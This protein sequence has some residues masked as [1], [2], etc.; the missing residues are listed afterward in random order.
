VSGRPI[1]AFAWVTNEPEFGDKARSL[2]N[3]QPT[4]VMT[5]RVTGKSLIFA[6]VMDP[7]LFDDVSG[8][9]ILVRMTLGKS[10]FFAP[11][12]GLNVNR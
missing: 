9:F 4:P 10:I 7:L 6:R 11:V 5:A 2:M 1:T 12:G 8:N 3:K